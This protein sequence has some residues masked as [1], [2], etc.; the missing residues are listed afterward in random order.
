MPIDFAASLRRH[1][2]IFLAVLVIGIVLIIMRHGT[3][4]SVAVYLDCVLGVAGLI[5]GYAFA[6]AAQGPPPAPKP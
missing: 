3:S 1:Y 4:R 2:V 6:P 5:S